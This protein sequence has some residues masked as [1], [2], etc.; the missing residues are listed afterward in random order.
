MN[1]KIYLKKIRKVGLKDYLSFFKMIFAFLIS[2]LYKKKYAA[3]WA[4]CESSAEARDNGYHFFKYVCENHPEQSCV[5]AIDKKS[6]DFKKVEQLGEVVQFGT[7]KHWILYFTCRYLI[8]SKGFTPNNYMVSAMGKLG[9]HR[10]NHVFLQHGITINYV[11]CLLANR[12]YHKYFIAGA[13]PEYQYILNHF[14]YPEESVRYTGFS[15]FD[16][17]HDF[18]VKHNRV[19][20][21]PTWRK[22]LDKKN[23]GGS[24]YTCKWKEL[25][26]SEKLAELIRTYELDV[27]LYLHP[28][29][30]KIIAKS[31]LEKLGITIADMEADDLQELMKSAELMITDYSSVFFDMVYMK[32]PVI[33]YQFDE[34][35]FREF[36]YKQGWFDYH[37]NPF[38]NSFDKCRDVLDELE[39]YVNNGYQISDQ[40]RNRHREVFKLYDNKNSERIYNLLQYEKQHSSAYT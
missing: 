12:C 35:K 25:F 7:V 19:M 10:P 8:S 28:N 36:H 27:I 40:Y 33:F 4:I 16:H 32:K 21:M 37:N 3:T 15:R 9:F 30:Q 24:E 2:P 23:V 13:E 22:W 6:K 38:G 11:E 20:I 18:E 17:L 34:K 29:M 1:L 5:Y 26:Q 14:G 39:R 31:E